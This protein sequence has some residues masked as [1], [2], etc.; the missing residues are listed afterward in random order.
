MKERLDILLVQKGL[1]PSR[2][3]AKA[4]IMEGNVFINNNRE[5]KAG[6]MFDESV[7]IEIKGNTLKYASRGGLKLLKAVE[8]FGVE[9]GGK[10]CMDVG[11]S[12]GGFTD[13]MLKH[14]AA[15]VYSVD[16]GHDQLAKVLRDDERV[17]CMEGTNIRYLTEEDMTELRHAYR[18]NRHEFTDN[19]A[20]K[21]LND[22][23]Q[24]SHSFEGKAI[25]LNLRE[26][27][28][29]EWKGDMTI[30]LDGIP[31]ENSGFGT[32]NMFKSE[33]FLSQFYITWSSMAALCDVFRF[34]GQ[35]Q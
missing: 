12:T 26:S 4:M 1:A 31:L 32:Q 15:R 3:K 34:F 9:L 8:S 30:S 24:Q 13:C 29:D 27:G 5:D 16:V 6:T 2:E 14:G 25:S 33:I 20:V 11:A 21:R 10:V 35:A 22:K 28:I 7:E 19:Q 18:A 23:L 17:V